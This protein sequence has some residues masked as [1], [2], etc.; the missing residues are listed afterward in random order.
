MSKHKKEVRAKA[1][2][3]LQRHLNYFY[4]LGYKQYM[5][6]VSKYNFVA[7]W[8]HAVNDKG[9]DIYLS[10]RV[11]LDM[12]DVEFET[13]LKIEKR[14]C[15][16]RTLKGFDLKDCDGKPMQLLYTRKLKEKHILIG[17]AR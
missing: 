10:L 8:L 1:V 6:S 13:E 3:V 16:K 12:L 17:Y 15:V 11:D 14:V 5:S 7:V 4:K 2:Q 9:Q